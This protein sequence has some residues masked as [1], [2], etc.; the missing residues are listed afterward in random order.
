MLP[1]QALGFRLRDVHEEAFPE[2]AG[3]I[4]LYR[5]LPLDHEQGEVPGIII[6]QGEDSPND[7]VSTM[8]RGGWLATFNL[9]YVVAGTNEFELVSLLNELRLRSHTAILDN[10]RTGM[11]WLVEIAPGPA[12][13]IAT[14]SN[15]SVI[16]KELSTVWQALYL[17]DRRN[18]DVPYP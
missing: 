4:H 7:T 2:Y 5:T 9:R 8:D 11:E 14:D 16:I 13:E 12:Q 6:T 10:A 17:A 18:P 15:S 1:I 3:R